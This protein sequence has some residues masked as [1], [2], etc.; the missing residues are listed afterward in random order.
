MNCLRVKRAKT[1]QDVHEYQVYKNFC[2]Q[3]QHTRSSPSPPAQAYTTEPWVQTSISTTLSTPSCGSLKKQQNSLLNKANSILNS[4]RKC[5]FH[6]KSAKLQTENM[7]KRSKILMTKTRHHF[8][9]RQ[10]HTLL[11]QYGLPVNKSRL[12]KYW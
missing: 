3:T 5:K 4:L 9:Q 8:L 2:R 6:E 12:L 1:L 7:Y 11:I 10:S